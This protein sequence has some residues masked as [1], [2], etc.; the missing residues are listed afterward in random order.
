MTRSAGLRWV[1]SCYGVDFQGDRLVVVCGHRRRGRVTVAEA[2]LP[3]GLGELG[4][5]GGA[6]V[7]SCLSVRE[8]VTRLLEAP[9]AS[10]QKATR[11]LPTLLDIQLPFAL[12]DCV[13]SF[14]DLRRTPGNKVTALAVVARR[15]D[16]ERRLAVLRERGV[17][18][19]LLDQE[20]LALWS[21]SLRESPCAAGDEDKGRV[22]VALSADHAAVAAGR[23]SEF[24]VAHR[25][26][27]DADQVA[28]VLRAAL[29]EPGEVRWFWTGPGAEDDSRVDALLARLGAEWPG[30]STVHVEPTTFLARAIAT[31]V[32]EPGAL[33]CNLRVGDLSHPA[34]AGRSHGR[35]ARAALLLLLGGV[36]LCAG[37]LAARVRVRRAAERLDRGFYALVDELAGYHVTAR[38][39][40]A[41]RTATDVARARAEELRPFTR[42]FE[43]SL[44]DAVADVVAFGERSD[45]R[46]DT[47]S[48]GQE[49]V[50]VSGTAAEWSAPDPLVALL[51]ARGYVVRLDRSDALV[52]ERIPFT[53]SSV[54]ANE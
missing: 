2:P 35:L 48:L 21:Q 1:N 53:V 52:D 3:A 42:V 41:L 33:A 39:D 5:D 31:R 12:E 54:N 19:V 34:L 32:L 40:D 11:V 18:P 6:V 49:R 51:S 9:F 25:V 8:S 46:Y 36:L 37:N 15:E 45:L 20:G 10:V 30:P 43:A 29:R 13:S 17:D 7:A 23:G 26:G 4:A 27:P 44:A 24:M 14:L 47:I 38:G 22:V 28:R 50:Q 16:V